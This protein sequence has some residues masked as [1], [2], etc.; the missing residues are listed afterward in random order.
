MVVQ[1]CQANGIE[2]FRK[3][4]AMWLPLSLLGESEAR[5]RRGLLTEGKSILK[6]KA[7]PPLGSTI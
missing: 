5:L 7:N 4:I 1:K 6:I 3:Q 2:E